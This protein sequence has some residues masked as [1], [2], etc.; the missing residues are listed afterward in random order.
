LI[1]KTTIF[2]PV[3]NCGVEKARVFHVYK[4]FNGRFAF[5]GDF[6]KCSILSVLPDYPL[7][8]KSK[9]RGILIRSAFRD[10]RKDGSYIYFFKN[11]CP[12]LKKRLTP[13]GSVIRGAIMNSIK[14]KKFVSSFKKKI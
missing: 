14:R 9:H 11:S 3:D 5:I 4:G 12:L 2:K 7:K 1:Q 13:R 8:K 10:I 6:I